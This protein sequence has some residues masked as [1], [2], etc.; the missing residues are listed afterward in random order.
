[1]ELLSGRALQSRWRPSKMV[2]VH[3]TFSENMPNEWLVPHPPHRLPT[4]NSS[5]PKTSN[6][7]NSSEVGHDQKSHLCQIWYYASELKIYISGWSKSIFMNVKILV[8]NHLN[9]S[10][11]IDTCKF[12]TQRQT[13]HENYLQIALHAC[14]LMLKE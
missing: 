9:I 4:V 7:F 14:T 12:Y 8:Y 11:F 5:M 1:M 10:S 2:N 6:G 3:T 13:E